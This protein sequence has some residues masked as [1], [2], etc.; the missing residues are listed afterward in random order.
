[1]Q[2]T[3]VYSLLHIEVR[4]AR[5]NKP[6]PFCTYSHRGQESHRN[7]YA[8]Q[9]DIYFHLVGW[10]YNP[11]F[12]KGSNVYFGIPLRIIIIFFILGGC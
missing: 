12:E 5:I 1:M 11:V 6:A 9:K 8:R 10:C 2:N 7:T 4:V 3:N